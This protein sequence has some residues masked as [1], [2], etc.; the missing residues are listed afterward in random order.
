[1]NRGKPLN[2]KCFGM[3]TICY[4]SSFRTIR[5]GHTQECNTSRHI[6]AF[7]GRLVDITEVLVFNQ[8]DK[9]KADRLIAM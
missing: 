2:T 1:M 9:W 4:N 5:A 8:F 6:K 3:L 7:P